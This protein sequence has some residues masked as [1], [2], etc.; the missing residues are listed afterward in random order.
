MSDFQQN[1]VN[2]IYEDP[3]QLSLLIDNN[4]T[5]TY[6][7]TIGTGKKI[8]FLSKSVKTVTGYTE[9]EIIKNPML[10]ESQIFPEDE[11]PYR[12]TLEQAIEKNIPWAFDLRF[13]HKDGTV[14][15]LHDTGKILRKKMVL[16]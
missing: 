16:T 11:L 2:F 15:W 3:E 8:L 1:N 12:Q 9:N 13:I 7:R 10:F 5:I 4:P 14:R 6:M